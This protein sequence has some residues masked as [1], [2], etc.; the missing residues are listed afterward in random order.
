MEADFDATLGSI[1]VG[2]TTTACLYGIATL[3]GYTY[4]NRQRQ[5][6]IMA[7]IS[8]AL[9]W[10]ADT[11]KL[12]CATHVG[13]RLL[14]TEYEND[15][16]ALYYS[17]WSINIELLLTTLVI[18]ASQA[19][20]VCHAWKSS[21]RIN[22]SWATPRAIRVMGVIAALFALLQL[23][24]GVAVSSLAWV[25]WDVRQMDKHRW[26]S[27]A[28][29]L[30]A[31]VGSFII[32]YILS[33]LLISTYI[34]VHGTIDLINELLRRFIHTGALTSL[35]AIT[36][37]LAFSFM[38]QYI[39][40]SVNFPLG[41]L[42]LITLL[43][44]LNARSHENL[45]T[46]TLDEQESGLARHKDGLHNDVS[47]TTSFQGSLRIGKLSLKVPPKLHGAGIPIKVF[48]QKETH[49]IGIPENNV[50]FSNPVLQ[51][52]NDLDGTEST[53]TK[54]GG[55]TTNLFSPDV[56]S[57]RSTTKMALSLNLT[58][59]AAYVGVIMTSFV[60][61][62]AT[63]QTYTYWF[64]RRR[65]GIPQRFYVILL[66]CLDTVKLICICHMEY[67]YGIR[68]H[69]NPFALAKSTWS[70]NMQMGITP[71]ITFMVQ[72][73][74]AKRAWYFTRQVRSNL[75]SPKVTQIIGLFIGTLSMAQLAFGMAYF[76]S[77]W[78]FRNFVDSKDF[79]WMAIAW[80]GSAA[81][82]D[83]LIVYMLS[84]ALVAQRTGFERTD[85]IINKI[86]LYTVNTGSFTGLM[87]IIALILCWS[88]P[89]FVYLGPTF[90]LG[91]LYIITLL[92]NLNARKSDGSKSIYFE[93]TVDLEQPVHTQS[94]LAGVGRSRVN[95]APPVIVFQ[96]K[97]HGIRKSS[98]IPLGKISRSTP[99]HTATFVPR[100]IL[101]GPELRTIGN[102]LKVQEDS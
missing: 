56:R 86:L 52:H 22:V 13:Y 8:I 93:D 20:I 9:L 102:I 23:S 57:L 40:I 54:A 31:S 89:N 37:L 21:K 95:I 26:A 51:Q 30:F 85:A 58:F 71:I 14:I 32:T 100:T 66:W 35:L 39:R 88:M 83:T 48:V 70:F 62:I 17:I 76:S 65:D 47:E 16:A 55:K 78:K 84:R 41:T 101:T 7:R 44:V 18:F 92:A 96:G 82:C 45:N 91:T 61:G 27:S 87:A 36:N 19:F 25:Y 42:N 94:R 34:R 2:V 29:M 73:Y 5:D 63:L 3:H 99:R 12:V 43:A 33:A 4:W 80:L 64:E 74:F 28:W 10:L 15:P 6:S 24:F 79:R 72:G 53:E 60:Y 11:V 68:N 59:G 38:G 98:D 97:D 69:G 50:N 90:M 49:V 81:F 77:T 1:Y 46:A 67:Y 75:I